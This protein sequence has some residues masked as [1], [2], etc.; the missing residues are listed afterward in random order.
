MPKRKKKWRADAPENSGARS[1]SFYSAYPRRVRSPEL[2]DFTLLI[3]VIEL[4]S[5]ASSNQIGMIFLQ[6]IEHVF[7][8]AL[9]KFDQF[10]GVSFARNA[11]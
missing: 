1:K 9:R 11:G 10:F 2:C 3:A 6:P 5:H 4:S 7:A 8:Q